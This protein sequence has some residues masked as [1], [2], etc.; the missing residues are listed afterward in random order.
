MILDAL[1]YLLGVVPTN[2]SNERLRHQDCII[3]LL[4]NRPYYSRKAAERIPRLKY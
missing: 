3:L 1:S 2:T 4:K